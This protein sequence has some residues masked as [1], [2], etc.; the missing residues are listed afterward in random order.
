MVGRGGGG[1]PGGLG[2]GASGTVDVGSVSGGGGVEAQALKV[3]C[4]VVKPWLHGSH[5]SVITKNY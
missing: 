4:Q 3:V 5:N 1:S 2:A